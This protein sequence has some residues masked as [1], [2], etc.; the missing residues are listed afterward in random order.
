MFKN[1]RKHFK[2]SKMGKE[3]H[4]RLPI[5]NAKIIKRHLDLEEMDFLIHHWGYIPNSYWKDVSLIEKFLKTNLNIDDINLAIILYEMACKS[6]TSERMNFRKKNLEPALLE[7]S[8]SILGIIDYF[9][10]HPNNIEAIK[11]D[12]Q[13]S[14]KLNKNTKK[15]VLEINA[16]KDRNP[17]TIKITGAETIGLILKAMMDMEKYFESLALRQKKSNINKIKGDYKVYLRKRFAKVLY[18][19]F[20]DINRKASD[21]EIFNTGGYLLHYIGLM[22]STKKNL[23]YP[24]IA[25]TFFVSNF[26]KAYHSKLD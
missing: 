26:K 2:T 11:F 10:K 14:E 7:G 23:K 1:V 17:K 8:N 5:T 12:I 13:Q 15:S 6:G 16:K 24:N 3:T 22:P 19:Y 9:K 25:K 4:R 20:R 18:K 21:S